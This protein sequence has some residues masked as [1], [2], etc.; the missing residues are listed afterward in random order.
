MQARYGVGH[1]APKPGEVL[2]TAWDGSLDFAEAE[3]PSETDGDRLEASYLVDRSAAA[4]V[5]LRQGRTS[6]CTSSRPG[7][8]WRAHVNASPL[9][10]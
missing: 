6:T 2:V 8:N 7:A 9:S 5:T 1:A 10:P 3:G 4:Q